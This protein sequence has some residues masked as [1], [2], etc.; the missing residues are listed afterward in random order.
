MYSLALTRPGLRNPRILPPKHLDER[1]VECPANPV[2]VRRRSGILIF[3][4]HLV[5][6]CCALAATGSAC[7]AGSLWCFAGELPA[8]SLGNRARAAAY[9]P[10]NGA[11]TLW[12]GIERSIRHF[13][14]S[15]KMTFA[16]I[17]EIFICRHLQ[18]PLEGDR[19]FVLIIRVG[20]KALRRLFAGASNAAEPGWLGIGRLFDHMYC[21]DHAIFPSSSR[22][23]ADLLKMGIPAEGKTWRK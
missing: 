17:A 16:R 3:A 14:A 15:L 22:I 2:P 6:A 8:A 4:E 12:T 10:A 7:G 20:R 19:V 18:V 13:L 1:N 23:R 5:V 21:I 9:E 11:A